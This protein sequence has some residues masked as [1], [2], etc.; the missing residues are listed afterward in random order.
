MLDVVLDQID[1]ILQFLPIS[2][3]FL[4]VES[5]KTPN[6]LIATMLQNEAESLSS[7][8]YYGLSGRGK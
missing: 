1:Q 6:S 2:S 4:M 7:K 5:A 8:P 3:D